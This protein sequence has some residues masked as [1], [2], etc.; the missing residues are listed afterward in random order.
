MDRQRLRGCNRSPFIS[1][2]AISSGGILDKSRHQ[3]CVSFE[4]TLIPGAKLLTDTQSTDVHFVT[5]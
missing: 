1:A 2:P 4:H 5:S 3:V